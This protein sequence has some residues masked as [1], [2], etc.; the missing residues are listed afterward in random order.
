MA[1]SAFE[2]V[3]NFCVHESGDS[4]F[5]GLQDTGRAGPVRTIPVPV[6]TVDAYMAEAGLERLD[7][8]KI[9][10]EGA[11]LFVLRGAT[12]ALRTCRPVIIF[13]ANRPNLDS[14]RIHPAELMRLLHDAGY[15]IVTITG[16]S[17][18][19]NSFEDAME[20]GEEFA[21]FPVPLPRDTA[22]AE[23]GAIGEKINVVGMDEN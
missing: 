5:D 11:E 3:S 19:E 12:L 17:L 9:D 13:E 15:R 23:S 16:E 2:G 21:A 14:Y 22:L 20:S 7:L 10:T 6:T 4:A 8:M 18:E 1:V